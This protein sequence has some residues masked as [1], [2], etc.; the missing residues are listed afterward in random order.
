ML[1][2]HPPPRPASE[3]WRRPLE[4]AQLSRPGFAAPCAWSDLLNRPP[5]PES[6]GGSS[7]AETI[8]KPQR[9]AEE[10]WK[11]GPVCRAA[12][13]G[14]AAGCQC[15]HV[16]VV[17]AGWLASC[18]PAC[19]APTPR[20]PRTPPPPPLVSPTPRP[21]SLPLSPPRFGSGADVLTRTRPHSLCHGSGLLPDP[22]GTTPSP[23]ATSSTRHAP[24]QQINERSADGPGPLLTPC[25]P[26]HG[27]ANP[28]PR[29][30][31]LSVRWS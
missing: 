24:R 7:R 15:E 6:A 17:A 18:E 10:A 11:A 13:V 9:L 30:P 5:A 23:Q 2:L 21:P 8:E 28:G 16:P 14:Q 25:D 12:A 4:W 27:A 26:G 1:I 20:Q 29:I 22:S 3:K 31:R 19:D